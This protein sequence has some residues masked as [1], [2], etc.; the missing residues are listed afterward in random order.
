MNV[1]FLEVR[2][3][4]KLF[5]LTVLAAAF[6]A[7]SACKV[8]E[9]ELLDRPFETAYGQWSTRG[10]IGKMGVL[11]LKVYD[12]KDK[13]G[14]DVP[15]MDFKSDFGTQTLTYDTP[16]KEKP[17]V[18]TIQW[19]DYNKK[20]ST[21]SATARMRVTITVFDKNQIYLRTNAKNMGGADFFRE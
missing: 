6:I 9:A 12:D 11:S 2:M 21:K 5:F 10:K 13:N 7:A 19:Y 18:Y 8:D 3:K 16:T 20:S 15:L 17:A 14:K 4:T 1:Y